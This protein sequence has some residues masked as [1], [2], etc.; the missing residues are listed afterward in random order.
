MGL[1]IQ[2]GFSFEEFFNS[3]ISTLSSNVFIFLIKISLLVLD[4]GDTGIVQS[5]K[6]LMMELIKN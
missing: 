1:I 3:L 2:S 6:W 5:I 4:F